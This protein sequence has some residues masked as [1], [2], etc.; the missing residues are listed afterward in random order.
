MRARGTR[1]GGAK[2]SEIRVL[3]IREMIRLG[4]TQREIAIECGV[5]QATV[6][7]I[8]HRKTWGWLELGR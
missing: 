4:K 2:L 3:I 5:S 8:K 6:S 1:S 7:M